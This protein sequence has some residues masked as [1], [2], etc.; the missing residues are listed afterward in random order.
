MICA[1]TPGSGSPDACQGDSGGPL[2]ATAGGVAKL[3]GL[4]AF[5]GERCG[6]PSAPG[7]YT[8]VS[9]EIPWIGRAL[10]AAPPPGR[11]PTV[12]THV[13]RISCAAALCTI[14]VSVTGDVGAVGRIVVWVSRSGA[15]TVERSS[16][17]AR[18]GQHTGAPGSI[19]R[20]VRCISPRSPS[21]RPG[22]RLATR[23]AKTCASAPGDVDRTG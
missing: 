18:T 22:P 16:A 20:S 17:A 11:R 4:V 15:A 19:F 23:A 12:T 14:Q 5:G 8:R 7:V 13:G 10:G 3:V 9:A 1:G 6:D 21:R 2:L